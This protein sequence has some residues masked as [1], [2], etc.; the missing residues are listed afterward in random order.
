MLRPLFEAPGTLS[1][2]QS[3][4]HCPWHQQ[5]DRAEIVLRAIWEPALLFWEALLEPKALAEAAWA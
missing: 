4:S 5:L 3:P 1:H 2:S